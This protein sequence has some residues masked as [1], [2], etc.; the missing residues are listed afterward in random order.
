[1][2]KHYSLHVYNE[3]EHASAT[4]NLN[5]KSLTNVK[6]AIKYT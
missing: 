5:D 3:T 6:S 2:G 4:L 1:M